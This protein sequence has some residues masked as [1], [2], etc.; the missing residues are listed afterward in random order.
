MEYGYLKKIRKEVLK[1]L[2]KE[3]RITIISN[4]CL[5]AYL[6]Q[7]Y[8]IEYQ[9]PT[10]G[11]QII[12]EEFVELCHYFEDYIN[13]E[14]KLDDAPVKEKYAALYGEREVKDLGFPIASL[15][16]ISIYLQHYKSFE[17]A[18]NKW[19]RRVKRIN[20]ERLFFILVDAESNLSRKLLLQFDSLPINKKILTGNIDNG[21]ID[22][23][24][25]IP[26]IGEKKTWFECG[27]YGRKVYE[28]YKWYKWFNNG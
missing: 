5:A 16:N 13:E 20:Y 23:V 25:F 6:Y 1:R 8:K 9:S 26:G 27:K 18:K 7:D 19:D 22:S 12:P 21:D 24:I 4:N 28:Q 15:N 2:V 17:E 10:I 14:L 3:K 11:L